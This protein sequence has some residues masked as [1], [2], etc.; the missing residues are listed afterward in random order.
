MDPKMAEKTPRSR[1]WNQPEFTLINASALYDW[2]YMLNDQA[3]AK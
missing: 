1:T 3:V 2:K